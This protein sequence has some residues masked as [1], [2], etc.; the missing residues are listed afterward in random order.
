M[1]N[2]KIVM[3]VFLLLVSTFSLADRPECSYEP[4]ACAGGVPSN[5]SASVPESSTLALL[6]LGI[7]G[8]V[9]GRKRKANK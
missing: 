3:T 9:I 5:K 7:A 4:G 1:N 2:M 6:G 8:L